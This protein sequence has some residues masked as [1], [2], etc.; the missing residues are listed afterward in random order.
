VIHHPDVDFVV[1]TSD[2]CDKAELVAKAAAAGKPILLNKPLSESLESARRIAKTV[3]EHGVPFVYDVPMIRP[4]PVYARLLEEVRSGKHGRIIGYYH[5]FGMNFSPDFDLKARWPERLDPPETSGG[6]EM[7]N[8]GC[9]ALDYAV[10]LLGMPERV[11]AKWR[12]D[13]D[14]HREANVEHFGQIILDYGDFFAMI[15]A[16]TQQLAG[17]HKH[18][19]SLTVRFE[20]TTLHLDASVKIITVND[21][22]ADYERYIEGV[23]AP[24]SVSELIAAIER[25]MPPTNSLDTAVRAT[26][27]LMAAYRSIVE[28]RTVALPLASGEN[29][30][31]RSR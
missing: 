31:I 7:T 28:N 29:P 26:E 5:R 20:N 9:Y 18:T 10:D 24:D 16:G 15:E 4:V 12:K 14:V 3:K 30:L 21:V 27:V 8:M 6:G 2:P 23:D 25:G 22:P 13:W 19:N 11:T 1:V 17:R